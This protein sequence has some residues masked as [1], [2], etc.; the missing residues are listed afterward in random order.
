MLIIITGYFIT[1]SCCKN[2]TGYIDNYLG[3]WTF[4][5]SRYR[6]ELHIPATGDTTYFTGVITRGPCDKCITISQISKSYK[7]EPDGQILN[8]CEPPSYPIHYQ[9]RCQGF[10]EGDSIFYYETFDQTPPNHVVTN[11]SILK[12]RKL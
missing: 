1:D 12:G 4:E 9:S 11:G 2:D 7:V 3:S 5:Y 10:F 8:T 6:K